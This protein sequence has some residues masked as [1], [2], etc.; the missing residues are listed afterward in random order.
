M[1]FPVTFLAFGTAI[2]SRAAA[3]AL[4]KV[5]WLL[6]LTSGTVRRERHGAILYWAL[7]ASNCFLAVQL[8]PGGDKYR[9]QRIKTPGEREWGDI[10]YECNIWQE[11]HQRDKI[12]PV[13]PSLLVSISNTQWPLAG[14]Y[15]DW[16]GP[17]T[18]LS[19]S[20]E[21]ANIWKDQDLLILEPGE[22]VYKVRV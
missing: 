19:H 18:I 1:Y 7:T 6:V 21:V 10:K 22:E 17:D 12:W 8:A 15:H 3:R 11:L 5:G 2:V 14:S 4:E 16:N 20:W 9:I 13:V